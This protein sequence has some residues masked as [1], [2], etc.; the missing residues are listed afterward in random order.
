MDKTEKKILKEAY[1]AHR[2]LSDFAY[3]IRKAKEAYSKEEFFEKAYSTRK[4]KHPFVCN[5]AGLR[6]SVERE[7]FG[8]NWDANVR[9]FVRPPQ[10]Y[11]R[12]RGDNP[13]WICRYYKNLF[14]VYKH[15]VKYGILARYNLQ[16]HSTTESMEKMY[17]DLWHISFQQE[18]EIFRE[19]STLFEGHTVRIKPTKEKRNRGLV[20]WYEWSITNPKGETTVFSG[21]SNAEARQ[22]YFIKQ[23]HMEATVG[24]I[25][26]QVLT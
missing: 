19:V 20:D 22:E 15:I 7:Y 1:E 3:R 18:K 16:Y 2:I 26:R 24:N 5:V 11:H 8:R 13:F 10:N 17:N 9:Y 4:H 21:Y 14:D 12:N 23:L 25:V 6:V